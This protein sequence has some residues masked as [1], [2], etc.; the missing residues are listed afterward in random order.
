MS[1]RPD[2]GLAAGLAGLV[3]GA[4]IIACAPILTRL[5][6]SA[7]SEPTA[8]AFWR[9]A[10]AMVILVPAAAWPTR[11]PAHDPPNP[12]VGRRARRFALLSGLLFAGDLAT[13]HFGI[14]RTTAANATLLPNLTPVILAVAA[15]LGFGPKPRRIF[16]VWLATAMGGVVLLSGASLQADRERLIG[17][18]LCV[19]TAFWYAG[20]MLAVKEARIGQSTLRVMAWSTGVGAAALFIATPAFGQPIWPATPDAWIWLIGLGLAHV[21]GQGLIAF[22]LGRAPAALSALVVLVQPIAAATLG[23]LIFA[24]RLSPLQGAGAILVLIGIVGAQ[25]AAQSQS[26]PKPS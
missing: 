9:M 19:A 17:D 15:W 4:A 16:L 23:W 18:A 6:E 8:S 24:E 10:L 3:V 22:G 21:F 11:A 20:Y 7:G 1:A 12:D 2:A 14:V 5:A 25:R 13:W 26:S